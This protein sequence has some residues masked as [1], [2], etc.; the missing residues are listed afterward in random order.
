MGFLSVET[1][2]FGGWKWLAWFDDEPFFAYSVG[3]WGKVVESVAICL[4]FSVNEAE[5]CFRLL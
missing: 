1:G 3:M 2:S 5:L 4:L